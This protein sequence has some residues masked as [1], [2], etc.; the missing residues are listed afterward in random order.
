MSNEDFSVKHLDDDQKKIASVIIKAI[1]KINKR[2]PYG[3]GCKAF[4][5]PKEWEERNEDYG[6]DAKLI[7]VHDGGDLAPLCN[8]SYCDY[9]G[10]E[11]FR[12]AIEKAGL[13]I[14]QCT[15]WYSGVY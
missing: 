7:L 15:S 12:K 11:K 2:D 4:Y 1:K 6:R 14:E 10:I 5:T 9:S 8:Y 3:G 13:H